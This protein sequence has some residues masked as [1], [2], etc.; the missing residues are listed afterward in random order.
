[1]GKTILTIY[2]KITRNVTMTT[3]IELT[4]EL[5]Q[6]VIKRSLSYTYNKKLDEN[7]STRIPNSS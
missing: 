6:L 2:T 7:A 1:M 5:H 4:N 3:Y